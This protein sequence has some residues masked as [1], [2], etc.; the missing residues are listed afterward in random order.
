[1]PSDHVTIQGAIDAAV[2]GD[3]IV[4][5][6]GTYNEYELNTGGKDIVIIG[7]SI[8]TNGDTD[9]TIDAQGQ[10]SVFVFDSGETQTTQLTSLIITGGASTLGAGVYCNG[11][12]P[13]LTNCTIHSNAAT[14]YGGGLCAANAASPRIDSCLITANTATS[15]AGLYLNSDST[16]T[17]CSV[18]SNTASVYGGGVR[19]YSSDS[20][21][22]N[23]L[24]A[25][26]TAAF[27]GGL[28]AAL[29]DCSITD[30]S[31]LSN[32]A[33]NGGGVHHND[34]V[35]TLTDASIQGNSATDSGGG[36]YN[37][38]AGTLTALGVTLN[39]NTAA[40]YGGG[41]HVAAT[42][43]TVGHSM[44]SCIFTQNSALYGGGASVVGNTV[45]FSYCT[46]GAT[47]LRGEQIGNAAS[48]GGGMYYYGSS[49]GITRSEV[50]YNTATIDGGGIYLDSSSNPNISSV[51]LNGNDASDDGG[52]IAA[53]GGSDPT[54]FNCT[55]QNNDA[56]DAGGGIYAKF[57]N[58]GVEASRFVSN[59][60][61]VGG[62]M[63]G[64]IP[65]LGGNRG[66]I[67]V[68]HVGSSKF[69]ANTPSH[70]AGLVVNAGDNVQPDLNG[71]GR[72]SST[73]LS[74]LLDAWQRGAPAGD[75]D[76][77][78]DGLDNLIDLID[79]LKNWGLCSN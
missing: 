61:A 19:I 75:P 46:F 52:G 1:V 67:E 18:T 40:N 51:T 42:R 9:V 62:G 30:C 39:Q 64:A 68:G 37:E 77:N 4:I 60:A 2:N 28:A 38:G 7:S 13:T 15:G 3:T 23:C 6:P 41:V 71:S 16:V 26:N 20:S 25:G 73:D 47:T 72:V 21:I 24:I 54:I 31:I 34:G 56:A 36:M 29:S 22:D 76:V 44:T 43:G 12:S 35:L 50:E 78:F 63:Y 59:Q 79:M 58:P 70:L 33:D 69:C 27:G 45:S 48:Y 49:G 57:S 65:F 11:S 5:S 10:G 14:F 66:A 74:D 32:N 17:N 55:F 8:R 53:L